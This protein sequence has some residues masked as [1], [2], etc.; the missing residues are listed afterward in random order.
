[1]NCMVADK[2]MVFSCLLTAP[3]SAPA[4]QRGPPSALSR[5]VQKPGP[6]CGVFSWYLYLSG[7]QRPWAE[8]RGVKGF[9]DIEGRCTFEG[10]GIQPFIR[11]QGQGKAL[12][13]GETESRL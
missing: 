4:L 8:F 6:G 5:E 9:K 11:S 13:V 7:S 12:G 1:M 3:S 2:T 10:T